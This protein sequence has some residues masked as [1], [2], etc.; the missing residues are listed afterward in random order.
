MSLCANATGDISPPEICVEGEAQVPVTIAYRDVE[1]G[2]ACLDLLIGSRLV[3]EL[4]AVEQ[5]AAGHAA[6]LR[7]YLIAAGHALGLLINFN[8]SLLRNG[9]HRVIRSES[10]S[11][12]NL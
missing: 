6:Q 10:T 3:V 12:A 9:D 11:P 2:S 1:V 4:K 5:P 8:V 7:S